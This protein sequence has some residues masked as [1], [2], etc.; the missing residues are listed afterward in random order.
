MTI[1]RIAGTFPV[2]GVLR[3]MYYRAILSDGNAYAPT[4]RARLRGG[5]F[6]GRR[7]GGLA[8]IRVTGA[9][10]RKRIFFFFFFFF[11][12]SATFAC[13]LMERRRDWRALSRGL[14]EPLLYRF[15]FCT[16]CSVRQR[17]TRDSLWSMPPAAACEWAF[18]HCMRVCI[19][20]RRE[21][22]VTQA[23][24]GRVCNDGGGRR[25]SGINPA[26]LAL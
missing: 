6:A 1:S 19:L 14:E 10:K 3:I 22:G 11:F 5:L 12:F 8:G 24:G 17:T 18:P 2:S 16:S 23:R 20:L 4:P 26:I 21:R 15:I 13:A 7:G 25:D 9:R